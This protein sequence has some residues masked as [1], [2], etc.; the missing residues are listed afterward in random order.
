MQVT[1]RAAAMEGR[2]P[3]APAAFEAR[4][5]AFME[6][7]NGLGARILSLLEPS[8]GPH[9]HCLSRQLTHLKPNSLH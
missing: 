8:V 5:R 3:P 7:A 4:S 9:R 6:A 1:A 2:W